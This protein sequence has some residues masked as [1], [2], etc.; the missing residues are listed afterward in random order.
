VRL[1]FYTHTYILNRLSFMCESITPLLHS[2]LNI[3][4][5]INLIGPLQDHLWAMWVFIYTTHYCPYSI[6]S[7]CACAINLFDHS[8]GTNVHARNLHLCFNSINCC[9]V[10]A[11]Y[12]CPSLQGRTSI[13]VPCTFF[14]SILI[15]FCLCLRHSTISSDITY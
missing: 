5:V 7:H 12:L 10:H 8:L 15:N 3:N 2:P 13:V 4:F 6:D 1:S 14:V 9:Q 11:M